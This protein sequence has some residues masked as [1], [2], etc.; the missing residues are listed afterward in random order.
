MGIESGFLFGIIGIIGTVSL[1]YGQK[2]FRKKDPFRGETY[3]VS[4]K[5]L[6]VRKK[7][8]TRAEILSDCE[9]H[10]TSHRF[11]IHFPGSDKFREAA[12]ISLFFPG[13]D[14]LPGESDPIQ[15]MVLPDMV[16][17]LDTPGPRGLMIPVLASGDSRLTSFFIPTETPDRFLDALIGLQNTGRN[18]F[19]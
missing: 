3:L 15:M 10:L 6:P 2:S 12:R 18:R 7:T 1:I 16:D 5:G 9:V 14:L 19:L 8:G 4:E 11:L 13:T 17:K